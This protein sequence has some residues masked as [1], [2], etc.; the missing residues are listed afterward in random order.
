MP[1]SFYKVRNQVKPE[2]ET[3]ETVN[4]GLQRTVLNRITA[5]DDRVDQNHNIFNKEN[6]R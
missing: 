6:I 4:V 1:L 5:P 2:R 3:K